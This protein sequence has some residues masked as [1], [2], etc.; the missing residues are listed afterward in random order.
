MQGVFVYYV[1]WTD[2]AGSAGIWAGGEME[3]LER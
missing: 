1:P 3:G 2:L